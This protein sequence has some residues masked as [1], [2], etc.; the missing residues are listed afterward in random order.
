MY[1]VLRRAV[2]LSMMD[3]IL[4]VLPVPVV[5]GA[6]AGRAPQF[7]LI[8][9]CPYTSELFNNSIIIIIIIIIRPQE[10]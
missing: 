5:V 8:L 3:W 7:Y 9:R 6:A 1:R 10:K 4:L 2:L